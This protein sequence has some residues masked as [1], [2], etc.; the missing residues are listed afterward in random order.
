MLTLKTNLN[1]LYAQRQLDAGGLA[2]GVSL[3]RLSSGLRISS[4]RDDAAGLIISE[5]LNARIRG[6]NQGLRNAN[7]GISM[8]QTAEGA[9]GEML[10]ALQQIRVLAVQSANATN[11][12]SDRKALQAETSQLLQETE[13]IARQTQFNGMKLLDG[14]VTA[15]S[16]QL[17]A[18][19][20]DK[21]EMTFDD[22]RPSQ[23][24]Q[25][26]IGTQ[27]V[28]PGGSSFSRRSTNLGVDDR[29]ITAGSLTFDTGSGPLSVAASV[30]TG[31]GVARDATSAYA[32]AQA[33]NATGIAGV[34]ATANNV[35]VWDAA[36]GN[37]VVA[38]GNDGL[39]APGVMAPAD[40]ASYTL[41]INGTIAY[42]GSWEDIGLG[43][44]AS[45]IDAKKALT[46][47]SATLLGS[48]QLQLN[49]ADGANIQI[50]ETF[51]YTDAIGDGFLKGDLKN[52]SIF[53]SRPSVIVTDGSTMG[54]S[55]QQEFRGQVSLASEKLVQ[56]G[57]S[58]A[59]PGDLIGFSGN[60]EHRSLLDL[61][62]ET[63]QGAQGALSVLDS[64]LNDWNVV[65][66]R[67]GSMQNRFASIMSTG[68]VASESASAARSRILDA[69]YASE[70]AN[71]LR[72]QVLQKAGMAVL[73]QASSQPKL[74]LS[75]LK[76]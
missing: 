36:T 22:L 49:A 6:I 61:S 11:T 38:G 29:A 66:A 74:V 8:T 32:K 65:R 24:L 42:S 30:A 1:A 16:F 64:A 21:L 67:L 73:A 3:Q 33:I 4:A 10:A 19:A 41:W 20:G 40:H 62:I 48:G 63:Q 68:A 28:S 47:V 51:S 76:S 59:N 25:A 5:G 57:G 52:N 60:I 71:M 15:A 72:L 7:D 18:A 69:D 56:I 27:S 44:F 17:G 45:L 39:M 31:A 55:T 43:Q 70:T 13:R 26:Q 34:T 58:V 2:L 46:G 35:Q 53:T 37:G 54:T 9:V 14:S 23:R 50:Q 12:A 75:L